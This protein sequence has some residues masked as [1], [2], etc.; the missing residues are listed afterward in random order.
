MAY[1]DDV[2]RRRFLQ[3]TSGAALTAALPG[4]IGA[5]PAGEVEWRNK[6]GGM[7]Y[8]RLGRTGM[9][10][11]EV[12]MGNSNVAPGNIRHAEVAIER[13]L[14][15]IDT[16]ANYA[17]GQN[18]LGWGEFLGGSSAKRMK[19]FINT[20]VSTYGTTR[21]NRWQEIYEKLTATQKAEIDQEVEKR[22]ANTNVFNVDY[23]VDYNGPGQG[24]TI[25]PAYLADAIEKRF[26]N[27][28]D[29]K[30]Y[31]DY[32]IN[33][34]EGSLKRL[35]TDHMNQP[36]M[37]ETFYKLK[38]EGKV[39]H[40]GVSAHNDPAT[41][42]YNAARSGIYEVAM[43]AYNFVNAKY[44][45]EAFKAAKEADLGIVV[46]KGAKGVNGVPGHPPLNQDAVKRLHE[47]IPG[48]LHVAVKGYLWIL[49][50]EVVTA[51]NSSMPEMAMVEQ[52]L[53]ELPGKK[54]SL[55]AKG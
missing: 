12:V 36:E 7:T 2:S 6:Q 24:N 41:M 16:A 18:E 25:R 48:D 28:I 49:Q 43:P 23:I 5:F 45:T 51:V 10:L 54:I 13:G 4:T 35:G 27:L 26:P 46:M 3:V 19:V 40:F 39:R 22:L 14:N 20:K 37:F 52:N 55:P 8:R 9:M 53:T 31:G 42:V 15:Y 11:S 47:V 44:F 32:I 30:G 34:V 21:A 17:N 33:S 38:K 50:Q 1:A 29:R